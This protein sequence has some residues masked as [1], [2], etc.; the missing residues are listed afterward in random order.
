MPTAQAQAGV[1]TFLRHHDLAKVG[2]IL[3]A[4][5]RDLFTW[6][7]W[8]KVSDG[9]HTACVFLDDKPV[10]ASAASHAVVATPAFNPVFTAAAI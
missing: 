9:V 4:H 5:Q 3:K 8:C 1:G 6:L 2:H 10:A 7:Q